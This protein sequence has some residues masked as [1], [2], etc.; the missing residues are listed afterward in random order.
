MSIVH[1]LNELMCDKQDP[2]YDQRCLMFMIIAHGVIATVAPSNRL[3]TADKSS[4]FLFSL[5]ALHYFNCQCNLH[6]FF[7]KLDKLQLTKLCK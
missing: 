5:R 1:V 6:F 4:S 3:V 2:G 7:S